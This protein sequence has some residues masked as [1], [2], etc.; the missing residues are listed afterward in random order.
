[1]KQF[2]KELVAVDL[3]LW[4]REKSTKS[5]CKLPQRGTRIKSSAT[6]CAK[7]IAPIFNLKWD[8]ITITQLFT[9]YINDYVSKEFLKEYVCTI[10]HR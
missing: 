9:N 7:I 8:R 5:C 4:L 3:D 1:M 2:G 10:V 6:N